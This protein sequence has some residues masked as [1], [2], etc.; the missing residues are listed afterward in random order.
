MNREMDLLRKMGGKIPVPIEP[1]VPYNNYE[2]KIDVVENP[3]Q[4]PADDDDDFWN[5]RES[6]DSGKVNLGDMSTL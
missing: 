2:E 3:I 1:K 4:P 5:M 6:K